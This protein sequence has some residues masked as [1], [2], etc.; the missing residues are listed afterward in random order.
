MQSKNLSE[1]VTYFYANQFKKRSIATIILDF[2]YPNVLHLTNSNNVMHIVLNFV[3]FCYLK[4]EDTV[5]DDA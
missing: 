2:K 1:N 3:F 5:G 4:I